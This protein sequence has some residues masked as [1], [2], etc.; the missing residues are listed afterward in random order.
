MNL[1]ETFR[2]NQTWAMIISY[3]AVI[4]MVVC[5]A[6]ALLPLLQWALAG[7]AHFIPLMAFL[8][9]LECIVSFRVLRLLAREQQDRTWFRLSEIIILALAIKLF[10]ELR[11]GLAY[12]MANVSLWQ[13]NFF[14]SFF[15]G[16]YF[17][18]LLV[19]ALLWGLAWWYGSDL[20][21]M[22]TDEYILS[23]A[24]AEAVPSNRRGLHQNLIGRV[25]AIG[26][27]IVILTVL[28]QYEIIPG[29]ARPNF[30][31]VIAYF[32]FGLLLLSQTNF[33]AWR[34]AWG[35]Q[36]ATITG[37]LARRWFAYSL[38]FLAVIVVIAL[39]LPT[40][41]AYSLFPT[42][43]YLLFLLIAVVQFVI[44][45]LSL[46]IFYL[47]GLLGSLFR[48]E[49]VPVEALPP[50][51]FVP[52]DPTTAM[53]T[54]PSPWLDLLKSV[55]FWAVFILIVVLALA[56]YARQNEQ[57]GGFLRRVFRWKWAMKAMEW[58]RETF[59]GVRQNVA[60]LVKAG[61]DRLRTARP[62]VSVENWRYLNPR[63]LSTRQRVLFYY[64]ALVRRAGETGAPRQPA[65]TPGEYASQLT[66]AHP[67]AAA[68]LAAL[69]ETF[70]EA[71]YTQHPVSDEQAGLVKRLW[72]QLRRL[73]RRRP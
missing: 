5:L 41:Y 60:N 33:A 44:A 73:L 39:L 32:I 16:E 71:R 6:I 19:M 34:A 35:Y 20:T 24:S 22:E 17:I 45:L 38:G 64:L 3:I 47:L 68:D 50:P 15:S 2:R 1:S 12:F 58:L 29:A 72:E 40:Q 14:E 49:N 51:T 70:I 56:Q 11:H 55:A 21:E 7:E 52:P 9:A 26:W 43:S 28:G 36:R 23:A 53:P 61:L 10:I 67:E 25:L 66:A 57:V 62:G 42:L 13:S 30:T 27:L 37:N 65:Q 63:R 8:I 18:T 59:G 54:T 48:E 69:T 46:P 4:G 31:N